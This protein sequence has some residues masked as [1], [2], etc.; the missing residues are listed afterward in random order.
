MDESADARR[1]LTAV[2]QCEW[3][4]PVGRPYTSWMA[5]LKNDLAQHNLTLE[6]AVELALN[7]PLWRLL[8]ASGATHWW[9]MPNN[10]DNND[11]DSD[12]CLHIKLRKAILSQ[13]LHLSVFL[14]WFPEPLHSCH[15]IH[16][17]SVVPW[18]QNC[19]SDR[20]TT[21]LVTVSSCKSELQ[22]TFST[23]HHHH[24]PAF[25]QNNGRFPVS[26]SNQ[27]AIIGLSGHE[28]QYTYLHRPSPP[29]ASFVDALH[30]HP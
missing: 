30:Y 8:A 16:P 1:I 17:R 3:R 26:S 27:P 11:L 22:T 14:Y 29:L 25:P 23:R 2:P 5:T 28:L 18:K 24:L 20:I 7:K 10:D 6:D 13:F 21:T 9:C 4:S 12:H 19:L 15:L